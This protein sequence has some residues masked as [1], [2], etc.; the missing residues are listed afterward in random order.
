MAINLVSDLEIER[1]IEPT[2]SCL[3][4]LIPA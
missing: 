2:L 4:G 3:R 1:E